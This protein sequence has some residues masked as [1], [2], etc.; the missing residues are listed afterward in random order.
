MIVLRQKTV[1]LY[2]ITP[3]KNIPSI[4]KNGLNPDLGTPSKVVPEAQLKIE[5]DTGMKMK[6]P[7]H[8]T[9]YPKTLYLSKLKDDM[10]TYAK[11]Y[12]SSKFDI[13][14][15]TILEITLPEDELKKLQVENPKL[16]GAKTWREYYDRLEKYE[17]EVLAK[18]K[19]QGAT[20]K[21]LEDKV[22][23]I[24]EGEKPRVCTRGVIKPEYITIIDKVK[25]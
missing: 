5:Q 12:L 24:F 9:H 23:C 13:P 19:L 17:P 6:F 7:Y 21:E 2:H 20:K 22:K 16:L 3:S 15:V 11:H 4:L 25:K 1:T 18:K 10:Y 14:E 8:Y